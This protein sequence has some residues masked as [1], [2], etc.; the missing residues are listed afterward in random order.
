MS[1]VDAAY[2]QVGESSDEGED[3]EGEAE[4]EADEIEGDHGF[5]SWPLRVFWGRLGA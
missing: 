3:A 4:D 2:L 1:E 5:I